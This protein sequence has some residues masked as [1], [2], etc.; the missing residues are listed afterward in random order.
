MEPMTPLVRPTHPTDTGCLAPPA[1]GPVG[2]PGVAG[3]GVV[4]RPAPLVP[5]AV[6]P[7][8]AGAASALRPPAGFAPRGVAAGEADAAEPADAAPPR[9]NDPTLAPPASGDAT[10]PSE[11]GAAP[12]WS[13]A[14][15]ASPGVTPPGCV[16]LSV[17]VSRS[18][19]RSSSWLLVRVPQAVA[20]SV[21]MAAVASSGR[22][23]IGLMCPSFEWC[24][25]YQLCACAPMYVSNTPR[26]RQRSGSPTKTTRPLGRV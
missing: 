12:V 8:C 3:L 13:R 24:C 23:P 5:T 7:L 17:C 19:A 2:A 10:A 25:E 6:P 15:P 14:G 20:T 22:N 16:A 26:S 9:G 21:T 18:A 1:A 11:A 4:D